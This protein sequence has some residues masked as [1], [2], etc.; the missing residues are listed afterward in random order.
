MIRPYQI[1]WLVACA[2]LAGCVSTQ[3]KIVS[4]RRLYLAD[5]TIPSYGYDGKLTKDGEHYCFLLERDSAFGDFLMASVPGAKDPRIAVA[6]LTFY[7]TKHPDPEKFERIVALIDSHLLDEE[8]NLSS[9][10]V[11]M[12][13]PSRDWI[14][15]ARKRANQALQHN[16][17]SCHVSCL[18]TPRASRGRG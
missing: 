8:V 14:A 6:A 9:S 11:I 4:E 1:I 10:D 3:S 12:M 15:D 2:V 13:V 18:R 16:D 17:P 7:G 5:P